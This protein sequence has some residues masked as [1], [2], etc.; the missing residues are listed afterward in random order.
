MASNNVITVPDDDTPSSKADG[1]EGYQTN[2]LSTKIEYI[3]FKQIN[4]ANSQIAIANLS[5]CLAEWSCTPLFVFLQ[6]PWTSARSGKISSMPRGTQIFSAPHPRA[7]LLATPE[8]KVWPMPDFVTKDVVACLWKTDNGMYPEIILISVYSD[9]NKET[10]PVEVIR[11]MKYCTE[12][13]IPCIMCSDT[14]AHSTCWGSL[15]NNIRGDDYEMFIALNNLTILNIGSLP[16]FETTRASS[17]I[18]VSLVHQDIYEFASAWRVSEVDYFSD[19]KLLEF[20]MNLTQPD[21]VRNYCF[22]THRKKTL[23]WFEFPA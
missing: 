11:I 13:R 22:L 23:C 20:Q 21:P 7:A 2:K 12:R 17:V 1:S 14:N 15:E 9:I 10:I 3:S 4:L 18:D 8:M 19:H 16:T 6:E 5:K